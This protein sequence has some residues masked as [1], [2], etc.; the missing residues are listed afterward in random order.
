MNRREFSHLA[1][2]GGPAAAVLLACGRGH[3]APLSSPAARDG[4]Q[5]S[6]MKTYGYTTHYADVQRSSR[7]EVI[8]NA[9]YQHLE[10]LVLDGPHRLGGVSTE[11]LADGVRVAV[12]Y[13]TQRTVVLEPYGSREFRTHDLSPHCIATLEPDALVLG[14]NVHP[15][16]GRP[17]H[18]LP[19]SGHFED[20]VEQWV[21]R[22][23]GHLWL[24][25]STVFP[26]WAP[27]RIGVT[28]VDM[29]EREV[30]DDIEEY[31]VLWRFHWSGSAGTAVCGPDGRVLVTA[32]DRRLAIVGPNVASSASTEPG[33][34]PE[35]VMSGRTDVY[36]H[37]CSAIEPGFVLL[38]TTRGES[39]KGPAVVVA[40]DELGRERWRA[41]VPFTIGV[42]ERRSPHPPIDLGDGRI[43]V[44]GAGLACFA[45]GKLLWSRPS[46]DRTGATV[47]SSRAVAVASGRQL[48]ILHPDG[49]VRE[50]IELPGSAKAT[51]SPAVAPDG[52]V[53]VGTETDVYAVR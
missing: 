32:L 8:P 31:Q 6:T 18:E 53:Y 2:K 27:Q 37:N 42:D 28:L 24:V 22:R 49:K 3:H 47:M 26:N 1:I 16:D 38:G 20:R 48:L 12:R 25:A 4:Q 17:T 50:A 45:D 11:V 10:R 35:I 52:T 5:G 29:R 30:D 9:H 43:L 40:L 7:V 33:R 44:A 41:S 14:P 51:T 15:W 19:S 23:Q 13:E 21:G 39:P 36:V 34:D 46:S